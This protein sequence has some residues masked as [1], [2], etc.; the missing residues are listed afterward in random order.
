MLKAGGG[1]GV[2]SGEGR[3]KQGGVGWGLIGDLRLLTFQNC[4]PDLQFENSHRNRCAS[5]Q[6]FLSV[7]I[8]AVLA[9]PDRI[10]LNTGVIIEFRDLK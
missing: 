5:K 3:G 4:V 2:G 6:S 10:L 7:D 9:L 1:G 8:K